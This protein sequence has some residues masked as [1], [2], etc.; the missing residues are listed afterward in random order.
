M[1]GE[2]IV[3]TVMSKNIPMFATSEPYIP[4]GKHLLLTDTLEVGETY[5]KYSRDI[6]VKAYVLCREEEIYPSIIDPEELLIPGL[7]IG[8]KPVI[9]RKNVPVHSYNLKDRAKVRSLNTL[10]RLEDTEVFKLIN[11]ACPSDQMLTVEDEFLPKYI[12]RCFAMLEGHELTPGAI[13]MHP[14]RFAEMREWNHPKFK[15][16][17]KTPDFVH[18][19]EFYDVKVFTSTMCPKNAIYVVANPQ[20]IG[21]VVE[22]EPITEKEYAEDDKNRDGIVFR[23]RLGFGIIN[24]Y[25]CTRILLQCPSS[26]KTDLD[27]KQEAERKEKETPKA[28]AEVP[29]IPAQQDTGKKKKGWLG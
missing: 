6:A 5:A 11:A 16:W 10:E 26:F 12:T 1:R 4:I 9:P 18:R 29:F 25:A 7:G 22:Y 23:K 8:V 17:A 15:E 20:Y 14:V 21:V 24:D 27:R 2:R 13:V 28:S 19:A 3:R